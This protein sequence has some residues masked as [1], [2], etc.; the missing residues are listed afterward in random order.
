VSAE[1]VLCVIADR[2]RGVLARCPRCRG[3][4]AVPVI[5]TCYRIV[6][7]NASPLQ[8]MPHIEPRGI[9]SAVEQRRC[10]TCWE[11]RQ[12]VDLAEDYERMFHVEQGR[13]NGS[14]R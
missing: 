8:R 14:G 13:R 3:G 5:Y 2:L 11:L 10:A 7:P 1:A 6:N 4:G 12:V 9:G